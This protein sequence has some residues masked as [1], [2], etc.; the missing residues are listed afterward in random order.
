MLEFSYKHADRVAYGSGAHGVMSMKLNTPNG[1]MTPMRMES[2]GLV[3]FG[4]NYTLYRGNILPKE[5]VYDFIEKLEKIKGM[6]VRDGV[7]FPKCEL[8]L[9]LKNFVN[10]GRELERMQMELSGFVDKVHAL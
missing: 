1:F 10:E 6:D 7:N 9:Q 3:I 5:M 4:L 2:N 8:Y